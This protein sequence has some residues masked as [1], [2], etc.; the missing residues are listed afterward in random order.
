M[1]RGIST[2]V[3]RPVPREFEAMYVK[4][5]HAA[6][7]EMY[8]KRP[9]ARYKRQLGRVRLNRLRKTA[10]GGGVDTDSGSSS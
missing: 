5:G 2:K 6:C 4:H 7:E 9:T 10:V 3:I 1:L 8:G